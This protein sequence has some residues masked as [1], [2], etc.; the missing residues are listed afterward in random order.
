MYLNCEERYEDMFGFMTQ[1]DSMSWAWFPLGLI[2]HDKSVYGIKIFV[3]Y[4]KGFLK[5]S[6]KA[7]F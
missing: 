7:I 6:L 5:Q 2:V 3:V 1:H 4:L